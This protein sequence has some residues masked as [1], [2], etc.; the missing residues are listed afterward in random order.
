MSS[1]EP[2]TAVTRGLAVAIAK[3]SIR[4]RADSMLGT[5]SVLPEGMSLAYSKES[6][7]SASATTWRL[8]RIDPARGQGARRPPGRVELGRHRARLGPALRRREIL[9]LLD[10]HV[11]AG[12]GRVEQLGPIGARQEQ[13]AAPEC[14]QATPWM[15]R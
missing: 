1:V 7:A 3:V 5:I 2:S 6:T 14:W 11:G 12:L 13:P 4:P 15:R 9:E 10:Q 8:K